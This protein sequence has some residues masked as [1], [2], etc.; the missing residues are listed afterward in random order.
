MNHATI[1]RRSKT[2]RAAAARNAERLER[3]FI[4]YLTYRVSSEHF[5]GLDMALRGSGAKLLLV[6][7][8]N[9]DGSVFVNVEV[10]PKFALDFSSHMF[11]VVND[12]RV[13]RK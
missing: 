4:R 7:K 1:L 2:H 5:R 3:A 12:E 8:N 11:T 9:F 10:P 13:R 6:E